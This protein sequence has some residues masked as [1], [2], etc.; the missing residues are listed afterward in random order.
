MNTTRTD[1]RSPGV[2]VLVIDDEESIREGCRQALEGEGFRA[3]VATDGNTGLQMA[4]QARPRVV[5][6]DLRMPGMS[7]I[8]VLEALAKIDAR[9]VP[10]VITGYGSV[11]SAVASMKLGASD[12]LRKPFDPDQLLEAVHRGM[13][14]Y[15]PPAPAP[16]PPAVP[17]PAAV[18]EPDVLL[19]GLEV[20]REFYALGMADKSLDAELRALEAEADYHVRNLGQIRE[21]EK[22]VAGLLDDL[23]MVDRVIERHAFKKHALIQIL[24]DIQ[25]EKHW[26]PR[27]ALV[28]ISR[29]LNVPVR[30]I[31]EIA[32]FYEAFSLTPQ[33]RHTVQVCMGTACHVRRSRELGATVSALLGLKP[34]ETDPDLCFTL[35]EV[36]CLGCCALAPVMKIDGEYHSNPSL[37]QLKA[38]FGGYKEKGPASRE[39]VAAWT[40]T[41]EDCGGPGPGRDPEEAQ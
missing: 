22:A 4:R 37:K 3:A 36:H 13:R 30:K 10:I 19:K 14:K 38:I 9:I 26:L 27:H 7:G 17:A 33:G 21:K 18:T 5:L 39:L 28:W 25:E 29:R 40:P 32:D 2:D 23:H 16:E 12:F 1:T 11:E 41:A 6:L 24:L 35:K 31:Y 20:Q 15:E 8:Q 34:G